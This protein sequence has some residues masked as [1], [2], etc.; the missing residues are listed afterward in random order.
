MGDDKTVLDSIVLV[1]G[2]LGRRY[3]R[4]VM[5]SEKSAMRRKSVSGRRTSLCDDFEGRSSV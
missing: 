2:A 4:L 5:R 1:E 3:L